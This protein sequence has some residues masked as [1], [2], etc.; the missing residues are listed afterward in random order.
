M[1][2][3]GISNREKHKIQIVERLGEEIINHQGLKMTIT[4]YVSAMDIE[5]TFEDGTAIKTIYN[6]FKSGKTQNPNYRIGETKKNKKGYEMKIVEYNNSDDIT[7][8]FQDEYKGRVHTSYQYFKNGITGNPNEPGR[9]GEIIGNIY[10]TK[11]NGERLKEYETWRGIFRR[12][13]E[14]DKGR[15]SVYKDVTICKEW[16]YYPNFVDWVRS[17]PNYELWKNGD[18]WA[19]DKDILS[20]PNNKIYSP[21][22]CCLVPRFINDSVRIFH[23]KDG[24]PNGIS[25]NGKGF[26]VTHV[27]SGK[28]YFTTQE[29]AL[30]AYK[31]YKRDKIDKAANLAYEQGLITQRC[32]EGLLTYTN[33]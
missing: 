8:E 13:N 32:Y 19:I 22:T 9:Y 24:L 10:S 21:E 26:S 2:E 4:K 25:R 3:K 31:E 27:L 11:I 15:N 5:V 7:V 28:T 16:Y 17:Q 6:S 23:K 1:G 18:K 33:Y 14:S 29:E 12:L 30:K 20:D